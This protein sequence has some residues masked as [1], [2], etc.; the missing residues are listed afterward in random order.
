LVAV[1]AGATSLCTAANAQPPSQAYPI[2]AYQVA[3]RDM[4]EH[5][6]RAHRLIGSQ[7]LSLDGERIGEV[8]NLV[9]SGTGDVSEILLQ[10]YGSLDTEGEPIAV[11]PHRFEIVSTDGTRVIV[12]RT[13]LTREE[14]VHAQ[15]LRLKSNAR[16]PAERDAGPPD[17]HRELGPFY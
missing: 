13:D 14:I 12:L 4:L 3:S 1:A 15:L 10:L 9:L 6:Y 17:M 2:D 16:A 8:A 5:Y 11:S 7:V